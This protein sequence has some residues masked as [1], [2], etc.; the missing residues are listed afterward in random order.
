MF[1][2]ECIRRASGRNVVKLTCQSAGRETAAL[3]ST[4]S[5][6]SIPPSLSSSSCLWMCRSASRLKRSASPMH[7]GITIKQTSVGDWEE[8]KINQVSGIRPGGF[9]INVVQ[10][11]LQSRGVGGGLG[12]GEDL[13]LV[14][15]A[16]CAFWKKMLKAILNAASVSVGFSV[17]P[18]DSCAADWIQ[19]PGPSGDNEHI[20]ASIPSEGPA[21]PHTGQNYCSLATRHTHTPMYTNTTGS[22]DT[23]KSVNLILIINT[24]F[25]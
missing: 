15:G 16:N 3:T 11:G 13:L 10:P 6:T 24:K 4:L 25:S 2:T 12:L 21:D 20:T 9:F 22:H 14:F 7:G 1:E 5:F 23:I 18:G 8:I 19:L 17:H